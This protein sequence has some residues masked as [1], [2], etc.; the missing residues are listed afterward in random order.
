MPEKTMKKAL[1]TLLMVM[2]ITLLLSA[3]TACDLEALLGNLIEPTEPT[4][5]TC[6]HEWVEA[7]CTAP[8]TCSKCADTEGE[9]LDHTEAADEAKT[10]TCTQTGLTEGK[11]CSTCGEVLIEQT[12]I[13]M[14]AHTYLNDNDLTC[15]KCGY[16]KDC[17]HAIKEPVAGKDAT[18]TAAGLTAG[19]K[20]S[21]CGEIIVA[22]EEIKALDHD[23]VH[24]EAKA[25][26]CTEGG[27][28]AYD[29][30][31]RCDH[32]TKAEKG[33]L[34]H[35]LVHHEAKAP[36]CTEGGWDAYD[37]CSRCDYTT[38]V[39][40]N[41]L[42]HDLVH[43][44]AKAPTCTESG[45]DAYDACSRCDYTT[46]IEKNA[47]GH[48]WVDAT[49]EAPK[50]CSV[51]ASTEGDPL[52]PENTLIDF[53]F[54][55]DA[56]R[57]SQ[58]SFTWGAQSNGGALYGILT[59]ENEANAKIYEY[60]W[61]NADRQNVFKSFEGS[62]LEVY[63]RANTMDSAKLTFDVPYSLEGKQS[64]DITMFSND[65]NAGYVFYIQDSEGNGYQWRVKSTTNYTIYNWSKLSLPVSELSDLKDIKSISFVFGCARDNASYLYIKP[66]KFSPIPDETTPTLPENTLIDFTFED[67]IDRLSQ[68]TLSWPGQTTGGATYGILN[69]ADEANAKIYEY[70]W[71][72]TDA[73]KDAFKA[74]EGNVLEVVSRTGKMDG[75]KVTF[76]N[77]YAFEGKTSLNVSF[78]SNTANGGYVFYVEDSNG[79]SH[80][81]RIAT[82]DYSV[83]TWKTL[84][85]D[86][87]TL[88]ATGLVDIK[89]ISFTYAC[90]SGN[91]SYLYVKP[92]T[93][94]AQ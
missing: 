85:I 2:V 49:L 58:G 52:L 71:F 32:N 64:L 23:L 21:V 61:F 37:T 50:T 56:D 34:G 44:E 81:W 69:R 87:A 15:E 19:E 48:T 70:Q 17:T 16:E 90:G 93:F 25:P 9:A 6:E 4:E 82:T 18:C 38:K 13:P 92:I 14:I 30:C 88:E 89:A 79:K 5:V 67:D 10:A 36:A 74:F 91:D 8:K 24:H 46:K 73:K 77:A 41:A 47:L 11:H 20:C 1:K 57:L 51:C 33:A 45:W 29:T 3:L 68:S 12:I 22:Q 63:A 94:T 62:I 53:T 39:E 78:F 86:I 26:T 65:A 7:T 55:S 42:G 83:Y 59:R 35:D 28:D 40:K 72:N 84:S 66:I 76:D 43:H 75:V 80:A 31:T 60:Q 27:W 54:A